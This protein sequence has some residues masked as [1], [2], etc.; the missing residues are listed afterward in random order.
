MTTIKVSDQVLKRVPEGTWSE[1][2]QRICDI[3]TIT[4]GK[5]QAAV[6]SKLQ[7]NQSS[8]NNPNL[9][10]PNDLPKTKAELKEY[11]ERICGILIE[12]AKRP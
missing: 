9:I 4:E 7:V 6:Q 2:I 11:I 12:D 3:L 10:V 8:E 5:L 1:R